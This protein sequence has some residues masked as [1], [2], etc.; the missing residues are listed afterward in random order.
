MII[1]EVS[2]S[3]SGHSS[4]QGLGHTEAMPCPLTVGSLKN[5]VS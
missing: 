5:R 1:M 4:M 3:V 2:G